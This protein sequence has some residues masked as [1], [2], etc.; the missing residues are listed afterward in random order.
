M[1]ASATAEDDA[2][3]AQSL[4]IQ[5][6]MMQMINRLQTTD[7][8][9]GRERPGGSGSLG[10]VPPAVPPALFAAPDKQQVVPG[11]RAPEARSDLVDLMRVVNDHSAII[12]LNTPSLTHTL[13]AQ[14]LNAHLCGW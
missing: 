8:N 6:K 1:Q 5:A 14:H 12:E 2:A 3:Q 11:V 10:H 13:H 9:T 4:A 7:P